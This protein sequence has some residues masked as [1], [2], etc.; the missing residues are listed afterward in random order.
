MVNL[1]TIEN[2]TKLLLM[3]YP[4][5]RSIFNRKRAIFQYWREFEGI[6]EF[7]ITEEQF[8]KLTNPETISRAIR[9]V[10]QVYPDLQGSQKLEH[11][12]YEISM[13]YQNHYQTNNK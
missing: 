6:S 1:T 9:R 12:R 11:K 4:K 13:K 10:Q 7:G 3:K 8:V 5:L 2:Q